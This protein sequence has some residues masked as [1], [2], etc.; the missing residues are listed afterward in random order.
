LQSQYFQARKKNWL[1][2]LWAF[3][4]DALHAIGR[5][6]QITGLFVLAPTLGVMFLSAVVFIVWA[7]SI[8]YMAA[9]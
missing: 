5:T 8:D 6:L 4:R 2:R 1:R 7:V 3:T 9:V